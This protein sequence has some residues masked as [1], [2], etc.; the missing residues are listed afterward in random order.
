ML[1]LA[2]D[3][4]AVVARIHALL[5]ENEETY[6]RL[7]PA[8]TQDVLQF[9]THCASMW[10]RTLGSAEPPS[11]AEWN[12]LDEVGRRRLHQGVPLT[13]VLRGFRFG[14]LEVWKACTALPD[15]SHEERDELL[16]VVSGFVLEFFDS[17]SQAIGQAYLDEQYQRA[18]WRDSL[19][20]E[21]ISI[22]FQF[23]HDAEGFQRTAEALGVD[24]SV[25]RIA[26]ALQ[27][28]LPIGRPSNL[29]AALDRIALATSRKLKITSDE[30]VRLLHR[31]RLVM[32]VPSIR[33]E[34]VMAADRRIAEAAVHLAEELA[35][36]R[37]VG[38]G[39]MNQGPAGWAMSVDEAN[40]ALEF[41]QR[42]HSP[43]AVQ[44]Y[45]DIS[46]NESIRRTDSV[47]RYLNSILE[48]LSS[49][50]DLLETL[51]I[52]FEHRQHRKLAADALRIHPNTLNHRLE[53]IESTLGANL[54]D[55][56]WIAKLHIVLKLRQ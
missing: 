47:L 24:P 25:P 1:E 28:D 31:G 56:G 2:E 13:S 39:L 32:W 8:A 45:S 19:L 49:E 9:I 12:V 46:V 34:S 40:K 15:A 4:T 30:L 26:L 5:T 11:S 7:P 10:F 20:Y 37:Y 22:V 6:S 23:P 36:V 52:Y 17:M 18:R 33:G 27:A 55:A 42:T 16:F 38:I 48:R 21:L 3:P 41:G 29:D 51:R 53:R 44:R 35:G 50:P 54:E 43:N 14:G